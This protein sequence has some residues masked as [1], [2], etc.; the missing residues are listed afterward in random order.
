MSAEPIIVTNKQWFIDYVR[1]YVLCDE[2]GRPS[3]TVGLLTHATPEDVEGKH[4]YSN[5]S[6]PFF[7]AVA[8]ARV[9]V[10]RTPVPYARRDMPLDADEVA[11]FAREPETYEVVK[12]E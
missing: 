1:E 7:L 5:G 11:E 4:I 3:N 8:A 12:V 6:I 2:D 10:I 9:T